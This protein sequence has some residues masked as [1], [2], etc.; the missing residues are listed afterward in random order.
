MPQGLHP[1]D[2]RTVAHLGVGAFHRAHQAWYTHR[3]SDAEDPWSI[4]AF[5]GRSP[6]QARIL[7][8]REGTYTL[9]T[10]G[11]DADE[12]S[13]ITSIRSAHDG[14]ERETWDTVVADP[15]TR[16]ITLTITEA[17]YRLGADGRLETASPVV[18]ADLRRALQD[19]GAP[20]LT[21]P[22]R[23]AL[24]L[25]ARRAAG[26]PPVT[27]ISC[28]NLSGNGEIARSVVI[29]A[30][31]ALDPSL[32]RWVDDNVAFRSSMVD[33]ITPQTTADDVDEVERATGVRDEGT[34]VAE[35]FSEWVMEDGFAGPRPA[36]DRVGA[37]VVP[38]LAPFEERKLRILNGAHSLLA[39][40]GLLNGFED[41]AGAFAD[42]QMRTLVEEYWGVAAASCVLPRSE[43]DGV[44]AAT[45][46]RFSNPRIRHRLTQIA[47]D[48]AHKLPHRVVP[49]LEHAIRSG[50]AADVPASVIGAWVRHGG[51]TSDDVRSLLAGVTDAAVADAMLTAIERELRRLDGEPADAFRG[52]GAVR[53]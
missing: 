47:Q 29:D 2:D 38:D 39:Y 10:R 13:E 51:R 52:V 53:S 24:G 20:I 17:G 31:A 41:V 22:V 44:I 48:G 15:R 42:P 46:S 40:H 7:R 32:P 37:Q 8:A 33:R 43:I 27:V 34:V 12:F 3:A 18:V 30:A 23:L 6:E 16:V 14:A 36:W 26:S 11:A 50:D 21:A 9:V 5:T 4:V 19:P 45:R 25:A 49:V 35:P 28:D 1:T